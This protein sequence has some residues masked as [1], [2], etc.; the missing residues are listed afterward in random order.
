MTITV[1]TDGVALVVA[2]NGASTAGTLDNVIEDFND[3]PAFPSMRGIHAHAFSTVT[4]TC[5]LSGASVAAA[6]F[7]PT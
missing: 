6:A 2:A 7:P 5:S 3:T 1:P 4:S